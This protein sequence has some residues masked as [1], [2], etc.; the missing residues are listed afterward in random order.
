MQTSSNRHN[1]LTARSELCFVYGLCSF[2]SLNIWSPLHVSME[3]CCNQCA[4]GFMSLFLG[5]IY[6]YIYIYIKSTRN[7]R[8]RGFLSNRHKK[9]VSS[10]SL[11]D[12]HIYP[13]G[14][15]LKLASVRGWIDLRAT[16]RP[17]GLSQWK[18]PTTPSGIEP[19]TFQLVEQYLN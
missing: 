12:G 9:V 13:T 5:Y 4:S 19:A 11:C 10:S 16:V 7:L 1:V 2:L 15:T 18:V 3:P 6:I 17:G 8:L 14:S